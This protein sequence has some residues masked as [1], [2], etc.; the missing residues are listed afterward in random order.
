MQSFST[1]KTIPEGLS[2]LKESWQDVFTVK[3]LRRHS[4]VTIFLLI[5]SNQL[6][7]EQII[8]LLMVL[9]SLGKY[10]KRTLSK[11]IS[12]TFNLFTSV[13]LT[14]SL[15]DGSQILRHLITNNQSFHWP[16][17]GPLSLMM[18]GTQ[19]SNKSYSNSLSRCHSFFSC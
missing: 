4:Y 16:V 3:K 2:M 17:L 9:I 19:V 8:W 6:A 10:L 12:I 11:V 13:S 7:R 5:V 18:Q 1:I 14:D 15:G